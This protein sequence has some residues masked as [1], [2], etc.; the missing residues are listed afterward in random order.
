MNTSGAA[1]LLALLIGM[2]VQMVLLLIFLQVRR[3]DKDAGGP[4]VCLGGILNMR[5]M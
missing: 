2:L 4:D 1:V 3:V 5:S